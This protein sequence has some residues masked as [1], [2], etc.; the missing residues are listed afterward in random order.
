MASYKLNIARVRGLPTASELT[1][2]LAAYGI[3]PEEE[4]G[5]QPDSVAGG[6]QVVSAVLLNRTARDL[7]S[8]DPATGRGSL[9]RVE[10][11]AIYKFRLWPGRE[12]LE[13]CSGGAKSLE[14]LG[15]FLSGSLALP[16]VT[17]CH[18]LDLIELVDL[19]GG[20]MQRFSIKTAR[21]TDYA[22]NSYMIGPYAPKFSSLEHGMGFI[23]E[24]EAAL[25]SVTV[26]FVIQSSR[27][28]L[29]LTP[30]ACFGFSCHEDVVSQ[31]IVLLRGL[32]DPSARNDRRLKTAARDLC[33]EGE[34]S[35]TLSM[36]DQ[37]VTLTSQDRQRLDQEL[38]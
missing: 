34:G 30:K 12:Q 8:E 4:F 13:V 38:S 15:L 31:V 29:T 9:K 36:G 2:L 17:E 35:V 18:E 22:H 23:R 3:R 21:V 11:L 25:A 24:H 5:I 37:S 28:T 19:L 20:S 7:V 27:V 26:R 1:E 14:L 33:P 32:V 16:T 10:S 6:E